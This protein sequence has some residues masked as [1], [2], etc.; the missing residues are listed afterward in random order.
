MRPIFSK[1]LE[2]ALKE[3]TSV[4]F[5]VLGKVVFVYTGFNKEYLSENNKI[6]FGDY[7]DLRDGEV[8]YM[9][10]GREQV[11]FDN[12][13]WKREGRQLYKIGKFISVFS[14]YEHETDNEITGKERDIIIERMSS[15]LKQEENFTFKI[16][17]DVSMVYGLPTFHNSGILSNSCMRKESEYECRNKA[18]FYNELN[19]VR[20]IYNTNENGELI[21]RAL[22]WLA[23]FKGKNRIFLDRV[24]GSPEISASLESVAQKRGWLFRYQD[25]DSDLPTIKYTANINVYDYALNIG[26]PYMDSL[27]NLKPDGYTL[28]T[29]YSDT[30]LQSCNSFPIE[31]KRCLHCNETRNL[32]SIENG[33]VC[34]WCL[35]GYYVVCYSSGEYVR[36]RYALYC[37]ENGRYYANYHQAERDGVYFCDHKQSY[38]IGKNRVYIDGGNGEFYKIFVCDSVFKEICYYDE[39]SDKYILKD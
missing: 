21:F 15:R 13:K 12:G 1:R 5:K 16:T 34:E 2:L 10:K 28:T 39:N 35:Q 30:L 29:G 36:K 17:K 25:R 23:E 3:S 7:F 9:P 24:Y 4:P 6:K 33:Y 18:K 27:R 31:A 19:G 8:S 32:T 22:M 26:V 11:I 38:A 14:F 20:C 37:E